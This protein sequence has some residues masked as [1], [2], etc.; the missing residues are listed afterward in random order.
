MQIMPLVV[1]VVAEDTLILVEQVVLVWLL[2]N[3]HKIN[4]QLWQL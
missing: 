1:A 4:K 2:S 3:G